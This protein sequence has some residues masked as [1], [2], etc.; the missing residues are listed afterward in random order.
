MRI[1]HAGVRI[2]IPE[3]PKRDDTLEK[4]YRRAR[5]IAEINQAIEEPR[6]SLTRGYQEFAGEE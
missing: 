6:E 3:M 4:A 1:A 2:A 5:A